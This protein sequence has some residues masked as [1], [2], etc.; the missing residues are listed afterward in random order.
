MQTY[1]I[2]MLQ[3]PACH[4]ELEWA[5]LQHRNERINQAEARCQGCAAVYPVREDIGLF[6]T[7]MPRND[8]WQRAES[9]LARYLREHPDVDLRLMASPVDELKPADLFYRAMVLEERG[10]YM[11][12]KAIEERA[13]R[14]IYTSEY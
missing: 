8:L 10:A 5:I 6:L 11:T 1:L 3:C 12:A 4:G 9:H 14:G 2:E 7:D 13:N